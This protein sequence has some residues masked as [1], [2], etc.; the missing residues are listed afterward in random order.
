[1]EQICGETGGR[2]FEVSKKATIEE[3]STEIADELNA[4]YALQFIPDK[5]S[6]YGGF[7]RVALTAKKKGWYVQARQGYYTGE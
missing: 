6:S 2:M 5:Q 7:H 3:L 1:M 4:R